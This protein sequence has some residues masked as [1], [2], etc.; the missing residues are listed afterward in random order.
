MFLKK[1]EAV[2]DWLTLAFT[3]GL[4]PVLVRRLVEAC[5]GA[6]EA[7]G[8][9][10][11]QLQ[12]V[13]G[14]G[15]ARA[16]S[17]ATAIKSA[18][19]AARRELDAAREIGVRVLCP[20]DEDWPAMLTDVADAPPVL[21]VW[22]ELM[23][24]DL[25]A[26]AIVGSRR[27]SQYG[28]EQSER[29]GSLLA[30]AG[31]TVVSG[32]AYG[33]DTRAHRGALRATG[34]RTIAVLGCG[35]DVAYPPENAQLL[36]EISEGRG[37]VVSELPLGTQPRREHFPR[38]NHVISGLSRGVLVVE[39]AERSGALITA[40]VAADDHNRPVFAVPGR[41]DNEMSAGP[42]GLLR[43]GACLAAELSD[44]VDNLGPLPTAALRPTPI[45]TPDL[46]DTPRE[47]PPD[48]LPPTVSDE[49]RRILE[50]LDAGPLGPDAV[51]DATGLPAQ[52][53][54]AALTLMSLKGLVKRV[55]GTKF[56]RK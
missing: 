47:D 17:L 33:V 51:C 14:I 7:A 30:G 43:D 44:I 2:A 5:G 11:A 12:R 29:F 55:G 22:G 23:A 50:A 39:A 6:G 26:I 18:R 48:P 20:D 8:A 41:V 31:F 1:T 36:A 24:R 4:G 3:R 16:A 9:N 32:G 28:K 19:D 46:F 40:R 53:V 42:H 35:V 52:R 37:A 21:W 15:K 27:P 49:D 34:G 10:A 25:N 45:S 38:R 13:S 56:E 54:Q